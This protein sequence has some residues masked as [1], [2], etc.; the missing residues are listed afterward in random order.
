MQELF[1][2]VHECDDLLVINKPAG[3]VCHPTKGDVYSS[4]ISRARLYLGDASAPQMVNRLDRETSGIILFAKN[5]ESALE[6]RRIWEMRAVQK[7]YLAVVH[8][9]VAQNNGNIDAP[10]GK[11][12]KS[13][14]AIKDCVRQDGAAS[15]TKFAVLTRFARNQDNFSLLGVE[16]LT[17]RKH[18]IRIHLAHIGHPIVGDKLYGGDENIYLSFVQYQLTLAQ[19]AKLLLPNQAL[20]AEQVR[21][22]WRN[23]PT[24][25][26]ARPERSFLDFAGLESWPIPAR[27]EQLEA[28][29]SPLML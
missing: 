15:Q 20:H 11:D 5:S 28:R 6:L 9:H 26:S 2:V 19:Q 1:E 27:E 24:I 4:L 3:L 22:S 21:F 8:G 17:G 23:E 16:P 25:F 12:E 13:L 18:Q 29:T 14:I 10:L 7:S